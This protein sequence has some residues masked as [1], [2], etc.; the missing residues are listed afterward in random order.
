MLSERPKVEDAITAVCGRQRFAIR[1]I[2]E[3]HAGGKWLLRYDSA[4]GQGGNLELDLNYMFRVPLWPILPKNS[5]S[6]GSY[7]ASQVLVLDEHELAAGKIAALLARHAARDL[8]D[9]HRI[10]RTGN[11]D[12]K[13]LRL[14]F[15][16]YGAMNRVDWR[17]VSIADVGFEESELKNQLIPV[18]RTES[19]DGLGDLKNW[20][21]ALVGECQEALGELLPFS[22]PEV[23]FLNRLLDKGEIEAS[24]LTDDP[25]MTDRILQHPCLQWKALN[26]REFK[27]I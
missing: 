14:G 26:V 6:I 16:L 9:V 2:P 15:V 19:L 12:M 8:F 21:G 11:L 23:E 10:L 20:A 7:S 22:D 17:T 25:D 4:M 24:L 27:E 13:K 3:D 18:L 1:R 5:H